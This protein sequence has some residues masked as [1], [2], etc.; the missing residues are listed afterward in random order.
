[1]THPGPHGNPFRP[2]GP[3]LLLVALLASAC[4]AGPPPE[5]R[6]ATA[7]ESTLAERS[8]GF[9]LDT[10]VEMGREG[11]D[12]GATSVT[13]SG[14]G[15]RD[16]E[17]ETARMEMTL[18]G[19]AGQRMTMML[20]GDTVYLRMP[21]F[22]PNG[23]DRWIR[24]VGEAAGGPGSGRWLAGETS[25]LLRGLARIEGEVTRLGDATIGDAQTEGFSLSLR[26][27]NLW[28][29]S[30]SVPAAM[31]ELEI[32]TR[33]WLDERDRIRR[34]SAE[35]DVGSTLAAARPGSPDSAADSGSRARRENLDRLIGNLRGTITVTMDLFDF[36][37]PVDASLPEGAEIVDAEQL[38]RELRGDPPPGTSPA[39]PAGPGS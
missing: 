37:T 26:G 23:G 30:V 34:I 36:G 11:G 32:P 10:R 31:R 12:G 14:E 5:Q 25:E 6:L 33:V 20:R 16:F 35:V 24:Q 29:D 2:P 19:S 21:G 15:V 39:P 17:S 9:S 38:L 18:P 3:R 7:V 4:E 27:R 1:M 22:L 8:A 13:I 28:G